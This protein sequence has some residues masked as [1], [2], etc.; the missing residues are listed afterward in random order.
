MHRRELLAT[1]SLGALSALLFA[2]GGVSAATLIEA[3]PPGAFGADSAHVSNPY[4]PVSRFHRCVLAGHD[5]GQRLRVV[6]VLEPRTRS[7]AYGSQKVRVAAVKDRVTNL[8]SGKLIEQTID[9]FAQ[10]RVGNAYYFGEDVSDYKNGKVVGH[11]GTWRV[12]RN[13]A[14]PGLLMPAH[15]KVGDT[16]SSENVPGIAVE[17]DRVIASGLTRRIDGHTYRHVIR[18]HEHATTPRPTE[19]ELKTYAPGTGVITEANG[20]LHLV[21]CS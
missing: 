18:I 5:T 21:G 14:G 3:A 1:V 8:Q 13:G 9:Y 15:P 17:R 10:D 19:V 7:I 6:R 16:F 2:V 4:L 12:G 20:E 11:P